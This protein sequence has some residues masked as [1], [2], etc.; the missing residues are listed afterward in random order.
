MGWTVEVTARADRQI[1]KLPEAIRSVYV[2]LAKELEEYGPYRA[3]WSH[4]GKLRGKTDAYHCHLGGG[5]PTYVACW[6]IK[7]KA[8]RILEVYYVGT[9]EN[10]P[11]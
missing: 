10:T 5:R 7:D 1:R 6:E 4:Y 3:N 2:A 8:V 9:H 11:Y